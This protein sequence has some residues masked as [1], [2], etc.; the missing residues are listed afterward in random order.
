MRSSSLAPWLNSGDSPKIEGRG[1][2]FNEFLETDS[3][4]FP[5]RSGTAGVTDGVHQYVL[6]LGTGEATLR[7]I[8]QPPAWNID[9]LAKSPRWRGSFAMRSTPAFPICLEGDCAYCW[10]SVKFTVT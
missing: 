2:A 4:F 1:L 8:A 9:R 7:N 5:V 3:V 10:P 6:D